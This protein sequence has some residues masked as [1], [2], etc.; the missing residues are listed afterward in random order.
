MKKINKY[1]AILVIIIFLSAIPMSIVHSNAQANP[2]VSNPLYN[3]TI[4]E[5]GLPQGVQ[6]NSTFAGVPHS[7]TNSQYSVF[8]QNGTYPLSLNATSYT[9]PI[10][11]NSPPSGTGYYQQLLTINNPSQYGINTAGSNIQ[12]TASNGTLLYAWIQSIYRF[13]EGLTA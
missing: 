9:Y 7:T 3:V 2:D 1:M 10:T 6:W 11:I 12:F 4:H 13:M 5:N 8:L